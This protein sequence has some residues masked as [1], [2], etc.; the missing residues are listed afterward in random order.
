MSF[1]R[2]VDVRFKSRVDVVGTLLDPV[3]CTV[4]E[5]TFAKDSLDTI[6]FRPAIFQRSH[7]ASG[8]YE[9]MID[10]LANV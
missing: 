4:E 7:S 6:F 5:D 1:K 10:N 8:I 2:I 9:T 3:Y